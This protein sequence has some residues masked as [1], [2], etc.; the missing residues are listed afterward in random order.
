MPSAEDISGITGFSLEITFLLCRLLVDLGALQTVEGAYGDRYCVDD[1]V[2]LEDLP[3]DVD[4]AEMEREIDRFR[5]EKEDRQ[6]KIDQMFRKKEF[7]RERRDRM[8]AIERKFRK[9]TGKNRKNPFDP[10]ADKDS[11]DAST[12]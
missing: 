3:R 9:K 2:K 5:S 4:E 10:P 8:K 6:R 1:H 7:E 11:N 12:P